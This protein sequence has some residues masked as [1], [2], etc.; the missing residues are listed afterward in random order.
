MLSFKKELT[1]PQKRYIKNRD[2]WECQN[3]GW[4]GLRLKIC[5]IIPFDRCRK[6]SWPPSNIKHPHNL[7]LLCETCFNEIYGNDLPML[8][9]NKPFYKEKLQKIVK[10]NTKE[11]KQGFPA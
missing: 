6:L 8:V 10:K 1:F 11:I 7:I 5:Y 4:Q 9:F 2:H 3:C